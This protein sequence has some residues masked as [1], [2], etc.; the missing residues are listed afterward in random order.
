MEP[1]FSL[2][3]NGYNGFWGKVTVTVQVSIDSTK[4]MVSQIVSDKISGS[5]D[6]KRI[7]SEIRTC[8]KRGELTGGRK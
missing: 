4:P 6:N 5:Q 8:K 1:Y 7:E 2:L 3:N